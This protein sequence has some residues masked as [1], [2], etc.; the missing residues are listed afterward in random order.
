MFTN[1]NLD[2]ADWPLLQNGPINLF[3]RK[4]IFE[5]TILDLEALNYRIL[6][7]RFSGLDQFYRDVSD[8]LNWTE[9]FGYDRWNGNLNALN[10]G[11]RDEPF[12]SANDSAFCVE[13]FH[14]LVKKDRQTA[15]A[16]LDILADQ[17]RSYLLFGKRLIGL[18]QTD[19][20]EFSTDA[21]GGSAASWNRA[22]WFNKDRGL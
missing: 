8:A 13:D 22:E 11:F 5:A 14:L 20:N 7:I 18:F 21:L 15:E 16:L 3:W 6:R 4:S 2:R 19:D 1:E 9:Q 17:S 12:Q 10:D